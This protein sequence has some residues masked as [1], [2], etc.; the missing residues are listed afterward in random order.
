MDRIERELLCRKTR[1]TQAYNTTRF[2]VKMYGAAKSPDARV[3]LEL[4]V[5]HSLTARNLSLA[6]KLP[7]NQLFGR[8]LT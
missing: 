1:H 5:L 3:R 2:R 8:G 4:R 6:A 7:H